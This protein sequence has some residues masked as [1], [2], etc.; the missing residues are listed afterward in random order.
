MADNTLVTSTG[1]TAFKSFV[2]QYYTALNGDFIPRSSGTPVNATQKLGDAAPWG[3]TY[4]NK[5]IFATNLE[6]WGNGLG[7]PLRFRT[8]AHANILQVSASAITIAD[9]SITQVKKRQ[10]TTNNNPL[11]SGYYIAQSFSTG[12]AYTRTQTGFSGFMDVEVSPPPDSSWF[13]GIKS[14]GRPIMGVFRADG[15]GSDRGFA[16]V[17]AETVP[18]GT[19]FD[20]PGIYLRIQRA[21]NGGPTVTIQTLFGGASASVATRAFSHGVSLSGYNF[22]DPNPGVGT[23]F[24][25]IQWGITD[26]TDLTTAFYV[27]NGKLHLWEI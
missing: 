20:F 14:I 13:A 23:H 12:T 3:A 19:S 21:T 11:Q 10:V 1:P 7:G 4:I 8:P 26:D 16:N 25:R 2:N 9:N 18:D 15:S 17:S 24:Y 22:I 27:L 5:V 6:I